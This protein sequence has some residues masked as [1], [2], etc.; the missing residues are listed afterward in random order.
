MYDY[1]CNDLK[2]YNLYEDELQ[3]LINQAQELD[4]AD[5]D[6][7]QVKRYSKVLAL[8]LSEIKKYSEWSTRR[9]YTRLQLAKSTRLNFCGILEAL[10]KEERKE[11]YLRAKLLI[12]NPSFK[13]Y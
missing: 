1:N 4:P 9:E 12:D 3:Q 6:N 7:R 10:P 13:F 11:I 8:L 5:S 2:E